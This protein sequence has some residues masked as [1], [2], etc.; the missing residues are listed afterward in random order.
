MRYIDALHVRG[1]CNRFSDHQLQNV[2]QCLIMAISKCCTQILSILCWTAKLTL[3]KTPPH[4]FKFGCDK[5]PRRNTCFPCNACLCLH[6]EQAPARYVWSPRSAKDGHVSTLTITNCNL[7]CDL[8][9][10]LFG[11]QNIV[12]RLD[13]GR[14][15]R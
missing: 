8:A 15:A 3:Y 5:N 10:R 6:R 9:F 12:K 14:I 4:P 13:V 7:F 2:Q 1:L 11:S